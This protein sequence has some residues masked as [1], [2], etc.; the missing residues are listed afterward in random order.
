VTAP[1]SVEFHENVFIS[2]HHD[3]LVVVRYDDFDGT[4]LL[5]WDWL[6]LDA[7]LD[8]AVHEVLNEIADFLLCELLALI[9][10][11]LLVLDSLL[12]GKGGPL[13]HFKIQITGVGA[14]GFGVN[15]G[16]VDLALVFLG[17]WLEGLG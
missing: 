5:L 16:E 15:D 7:G 17:N 3:I 11:E 13:V 4:V 6:A 1:W 14:E 8:L 10:G 9:Q 2:L 12:D